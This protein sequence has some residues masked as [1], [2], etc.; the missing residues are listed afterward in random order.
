MEVQGRRIV[1]AIALNLASAI[2]IVFLNKAIYVHTKFPNMTLT[3]VHF[4]VTSF[5][6][7][8]CSWLDVF[9]PK[10]LRIKNILPLSVSFCGFVVLTNLSLQFNTVGTYQ[11]AK[12]MTTPVILFIQTYFYRKSTPILIQLSTVS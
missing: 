3:F 11:V 4:I 7:H 1:L 6:I 12:V 9:S 5:G 10:S 2:G 8:L